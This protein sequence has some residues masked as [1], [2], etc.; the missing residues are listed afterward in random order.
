MVPVSGVVE[1]NASISIDVTFT[2][3][4]ELEF[5]YNLICNIKRKN[6]PLVLNIKESDTLSNI[7]FSLN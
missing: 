3:K 7:K 6:R 1:P 4:A 2:P 5:N